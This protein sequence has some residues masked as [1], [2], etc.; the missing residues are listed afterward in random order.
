MID[1]S[2]VIPAY[3]VEKHLAACLDSL[4]KTQGI[5]DTQIIIVDDG[6]T[7]KTPAIAGEYSHKYQNIKVIRKENGGPSA[8]RNLG[9]K[10]ASGKYVFFCDSDDEVNPELFK[11]VIDLTKTCSEDMIL[12]DAELCYETWN[13]LVPKNRDFFSHGGLE[14]EEKVYSGKEVVEKL[15]RNSGDFVATIWLGAYRREFLIAYELFFEEGLIHEDEL[16][17]PKIFLNAASVR[18]IPE[19]IYHYR[20]HEGS[21]MNPENRDRKQ[22]SDALMY[23]YPALYKYYDEVLEGDPLKELIEANLT[24]RYIH[25]IYKYRIWRY[26][27][28]DEIDKKLLWRTAGRL[29]DKIMVLLLYVFIH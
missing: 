25:M 2:I 19:R 29:R 11:K 8:S 16:L 21:I 26:G 6:S 27:Y 17:L 28:G 22:S 12:W 23:V 24:K 5:E 9:L 1:L 13:L 4:L 20:I 15:L 10:E 18:Y 7:D 3:N 14:K